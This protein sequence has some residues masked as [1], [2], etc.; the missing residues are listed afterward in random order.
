MTVVRHETQLCG[1]MLLVVLKVP[2]EGLEWSSNCMQKIFSWMGHGVLVVGRIII[3]F[4]LEFLHL[5]YHC[6]RFIGYSSH[7]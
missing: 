3:E 7:E 5:K 6:F 4:Q 1:S 2:D